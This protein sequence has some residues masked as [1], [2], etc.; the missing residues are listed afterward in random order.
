MGEE[1]TYERLI[2]FIRTYQP[3][4]VMPSF[5][6]VDSQHGHHRAMTVL[7]ERAYKDAA[8]PNVFPHQ[9]EEGL[10]V[11]QTKKLYLPAASPQTATTSIEIGMYDPIYEMSYP[12]L[13]EQSRYMHKS[14]GMGR[15]IPVAPRQTYLE[16]VDSAVDTK[17]SNDLFAGIPYDFT[18]WAQVFSENQNDLKVHFTKLQSEL[19]GIVAAYPNENTVFSKSQSAL[20]D[21][22]QLTKKVEKAKLD[23]ALKHDLLRKLANKEEQLQEASFVATSLD[24]NVE[25]DST[26]LTQG[27]NT[28]VSIT[29]INN[30]MQKLGKV[31]AQLIVPD[32]WKVSKKSKAG[33]LKPGKA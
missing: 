13:G 24:V 16:L 7:S 18:E 10:S 8:D 26:I 33:I 21:V 17:G 12:Q 14:Q 11:W 6:D 3:D 20:K 5:R 31:E 1:V 30:G 9:L 23:E 28:E 4:I 15:D 27:Q 32:G 19:D 2:R 29:L 25:P 22:R